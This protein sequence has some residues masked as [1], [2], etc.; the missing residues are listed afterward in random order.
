PFSRALHELKMRN[1][2][3][4]DKEEQSFVDY[5]V[6]L[7]SNKGQIVESLKWALKRKEPKYIAKY[8]IQYVNKNTN[9]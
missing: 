8:L 5:L 2:Q 9:K 6:A 4:Y 3:L 1:N 7:E